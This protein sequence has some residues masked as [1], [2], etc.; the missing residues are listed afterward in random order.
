MR[1]RKPTRPS[2]V[3]EPFMRGVRRCLENSG[4]RTSEVWT[5][6]NELDLRVT[7]ADSYSPLF[8]VYAHFGERRLFGCLVRPGER[9]TKDF[10]HH[11]VNDARPEPPAWRRF[12][13]R[14][15]DPEG[16]EAALGAIVAEAAL[17]VGPFADPDLGDLDPAESGLLAA[18]RE[19]KVREGEPTLVERLHGLLVRAHRAD[20][21]SAILAEA[22]AAVRGEDP[23]PAGPRP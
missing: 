17:H 13:A 2:A 7:P 23:P 18:M 15:D 21:S 10:P 8:T 3:T 12:A 19:A 5:S 4:L 14:Q 9:P 20:P 1:S 16:M 11:P 6:S 22:V